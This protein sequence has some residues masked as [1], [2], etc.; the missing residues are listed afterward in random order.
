MAKVLKYYINIGIFALLIFTVVITQGCATSEAVSLPAVEEFEIQTE[1]HDRTTLRAGVVSGLYADMFTDAIKPQLESMGYTVELEFH[2]NYTLPNIALARGRN[3][4]NIFQHFSS[5]NAFKLENDLA[6]SAIAEIPTLPM[7]IFSKKFSSLED[8]EDGI[9]VSIPNDSSNLSRALRL[10]DAARLI[11]INPSVDRRNVTLHD[12]I[13]N[14]H[15]LRLAPIRSE[16]LI[17][18]IDTV[19]LVVMDADY[20]VSS[21]LSIR[22]ELFSERMDVD[23]LKVIVVRTEDLYKQFVQDIITVLQSEEFKSFIESNAKYARF[24]KPPGFYS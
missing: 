6:L 5:L 15:N 10:L 12:I 22:Y 4:L 24:Q 21:G 1:R 19:G 2:D 13:D 9:I 11:R 16:T 23:Y 20:A 18:S 17:D 14:P 8:I 7:G 3:D